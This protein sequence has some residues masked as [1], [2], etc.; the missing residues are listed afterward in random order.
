MA[1]SSAVVASRGFGRH[2][3]GHIGL[4]L[5]LLVPFTFLSRSLPTLGLDLS[6]ITLLRR[7]GGFRKRLGVIGDGAVLLSDIG[8]F[9][10]CLRSSVNLLLAIDRFERPE[11]FIL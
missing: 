7:V 11:P 1:W 4:L 3:I 10:P 9:L 8:G 2:P 6:G 5:V